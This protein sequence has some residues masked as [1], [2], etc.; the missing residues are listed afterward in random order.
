MILDCVRYFG[1]TVHDR[2]RLARF[3]HI[4]GAIS[5]RRLLLG[6]ELGANV[7]SFFSAD[8]SEC[9]RTNSDRF[10]SMG[11]PSASPENKTIALEFAKLVTRKTSNSND[12]LARCGRCSLFSALQEMFPQIVRDGTRLARDGLTEVEFNK[13]LQVQASLIAMCR[14]DFEQ[15]VSNSCS[16]YRQKVS[17]GYV[18][19]RSA[20][21]IG[22]QTH[23]VLG[24]TSSVESAGLIPTIR[25]R[26]SSWL[27]ATGI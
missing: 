11:R 14:I 9:S 27:Q 6:G 19:A 2:N 26:T 20:P 15:V 16:S 12:L 7:L 5:F 21:L 18:I 13:L 4:H 23:S 10:Q 3:G 8:P 25:M 24:S 22:P 1:D 17:N